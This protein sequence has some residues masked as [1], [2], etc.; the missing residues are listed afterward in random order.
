MIA[1]I[2]RLIQQEAKLVLPAAQL[3]PR[4]NLYALGLSSFDAIRLL[5]ALER[6]FKVEL[7]RETLKRE[8]MA[9]IDAIATAIRAARPTPAALRR[10]A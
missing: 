1:A 5:V 6:T 9:T 7:P 3:T 4:A 10:A 8:T 2:Q